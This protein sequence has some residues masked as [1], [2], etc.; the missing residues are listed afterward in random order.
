MNT[1][2]T[3]FN[4]N[5]VVNESFIDSATLRENVVSLARNIGYVPR[6]RTAAKGTISLTVSDPTS[7]INGNTLTLRKGLVCTGDSSGTTY[8]FAIPE[9]RTV[10]VINGVADFG[11]RNCTRIKR[12]KFTHNIWIYRTGADYFSKLIEVFIDITKDIVSKS[13]SIFII[14]FINF[15]Y[16]IYSR[17]L[18]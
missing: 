2:Q 12:I 15:F 16:R 9:D 5:M 13:W 18:Y 1:Y 3:A 8:A 6:S 17:C 7:V 4:T 10:G 11:Q 14:F